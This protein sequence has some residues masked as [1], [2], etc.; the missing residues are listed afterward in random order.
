MDRLRQ[1]YFIYLLAVSIIGGSIIVMGLL[2]LNSY[3]PPI[4]FLLFVIMAILAQMITSS[5]SISKKTSVTYQVAP[6]VSMAVVPLFGPFAAV[7]IDAVSAFSLWLIKPSEKN[8]WQKSW[9]QLAFNTSMGSIAIFIAGLVFVFIR[10]LLGD[11]LAGIIIPYLIAAIV[12]DQINIWLL[13]GIIWLQQNRSVSIWSIWKANIWAMPISILLIS[14]GGGIL[15]FSL[16]AFGPI[17]LGVF[18]LPILL[19]AIAFRLYLRKMQAHMDNL[20]H[21][22]QDRTKELEALNKRKD[23]FLAVLTHDMITPL[24]SMQ[25][26]SELLKEDPTVPQEDPQFTETMIRCQKSL[27]RLLHNI[28]DLEKLNSGVELTTRKSTFSFTEQIELVV[29]IVSTEASVKQID[30]YLDVPAHE[31]ML[32]ADQYQ[33]ERILLNLLSNAVKYTPVG[34]HIKLIVEQNQQHTIIKI[35]DNGY[36]IPE[37]ELPYIFQRFTRVEQ[38]QDKATGTGLGL[39]ITKALVEAHGGHISVDSE[40]NYGSTFLIVLP[41]GKEKI[42]ETPPE[43]VVESLLVR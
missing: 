14:I 39:A 27:L 3:Q 5:F 42:N 29:D 21:L 17:G 33:F 12:F 40:I 32:Y 9:S 16:I 24:T 4:Y 41:N 38:L 20:E 7:L 30:F 23:A 31:I 13:A 25:L 28:L 2:R 6:A 22:V 26:Y 36:G 19:S 15:S 1:P 34:G 43:Q 11:T 10:N 37:E 18:F 8:I 35:T